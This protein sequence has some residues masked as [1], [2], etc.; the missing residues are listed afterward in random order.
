MIHIISVSRSE[1]AWLSPV[2]EVDGDSVPSEWLAI[3]P[4]RGTVTRLPKL[5]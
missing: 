5:W 4:D 1:R 2:C 3:S